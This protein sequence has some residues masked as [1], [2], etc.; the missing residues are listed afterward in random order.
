[1]A[2]NLFPLDYEKGTPALEDAEANRVTGYKPGISFDFEN[3][4]F[5]LDGVCRIRDADGVESWMGW[6]KACLVTER[7]KHIAYN[8]DFGIETSEAFK[9]ETREKA[10]SLLTR[11]ITEA[12]EA[13]PYGRTDYVEDIDFNWTAPDSVR[14]T[15]TVRGIDGVTID[16]MAELGK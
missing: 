5:M 14:V 16:V 8:T 13:D 3:G 9:A 1:M 12:L 10:Q 6:C 11:Q 2:D 4:D 15:V 7:Y